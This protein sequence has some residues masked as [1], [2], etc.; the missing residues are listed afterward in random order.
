[1]GARRHPIGAL[2]NCSERVAD[3]HGTLTNTQKTVIIFRVAYADDIV[4]GQAKLPEGDLKAR[5]F[6]HTRGQDHHG[7]LVE[8]DLQ[9]Q[10]QVANRFQYSLFV[11]MPGG[12]DTL[13]N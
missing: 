10:I 12:H 13:A 2:P 5:S 9:L 3:C 4:S 8:D 6:V 11:W 7:S 1:M